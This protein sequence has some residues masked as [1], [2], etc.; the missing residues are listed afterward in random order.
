MKW[1][2]FAAYISGF[3]SKTPLG[4]I[5]AIRAETD[6][7]TIKKFTPDQKRIRNRW[8]SRKAK[9]RPAKEVNAFIESMKQ[10]FINM[11]GGA[12]AEDHQA[13]VP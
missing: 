4:R 11:A 6:P 9:A 7:E 12:D 8:L 10:A 2:E 13:E 5:I 3:D 1:K